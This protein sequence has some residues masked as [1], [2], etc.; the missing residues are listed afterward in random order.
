MTYMPMY[1]LPR[2]VDSL[3]NQPNIPPTLEA[4]IWYTAL[5]DYTYFRNNT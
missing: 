2:G 5:M 1:Q 3:T 4:R